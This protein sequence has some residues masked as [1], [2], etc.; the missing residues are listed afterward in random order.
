MRRPVA[1]RATTSGL[2]H[3]AYVLPALAVMTLV[4]LIPLA[5]TLGLSLSDWDGLGPIS[6]AGARNYV[7]FLEDELVIA[8][9]RNAVVLTLFTSAIPILLGM[10]TAIVLSRIG[11][12]LRT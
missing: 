3:A 4:L 9:L 7:A 12:R 2:V 10:A 1:P 5:M 8:S 6:W 11:A